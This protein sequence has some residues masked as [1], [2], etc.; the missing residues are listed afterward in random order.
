[1]QMI[2]IFIIRFIRRYELILKSLEIIIPLQRC[3]T[4]CFYLKAGSG[5]VLVFCG[6]FL[7]CSS[8]S[9]FSIISRLAKCRI[10]NMF[11]ESSS[12]C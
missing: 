6:Y 7:V 3:S 10:L 11:N 8:V 2:V 9:Y 1:M 12:T 5:I 4:K